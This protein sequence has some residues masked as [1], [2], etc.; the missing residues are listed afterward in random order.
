MLYNLHLQLTHSGAG[1]VDIPALGTWSD[2]ITNKHKKSFLL[3]IGGKKIGVACI[4][5]VQYP[6]ITL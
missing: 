4:K 5:E 3:N 2:P 6:G 1:L